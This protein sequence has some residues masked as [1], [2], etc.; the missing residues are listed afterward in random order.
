[1]YQLFGLGHEEARNWML[2]CEGQL[3]PAVA[4]VFLQNKF[5]IFL[6]SV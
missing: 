5:N 2:F 1:M 4:A 3:N 6:K